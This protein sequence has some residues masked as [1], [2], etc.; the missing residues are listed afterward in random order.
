MMNRI[1]TIHGFKYHEQLINIKI[2]KL[3]QIITIIT[4][5]VMRVR[6][7]MQVKVIKQCE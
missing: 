7:Y 1:G 3:F 4:I 2:T 6:M 5:L